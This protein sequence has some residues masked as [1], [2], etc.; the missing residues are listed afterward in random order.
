[1]PEIINS[2]VIKTKKGCRKNRQPFRGRERIRTAVQAFAE[3]CLATR[4]PDHWIA[5]VVFFANTQNHFLLLQYMTKKKLPQRKQKQT[6]KRHLKGANETSE[7]IFSIIKHLGS[8]ADLKS[9]FDIALD[10]FTQADIVSALDKLEQ[11]AKITVHQRGRIEVL[12]KKRPEKTAM[13][14]VLVGTIDITRTGAAYVKVQKLD[15]D[16]FIMER[17]TGGAL[18]GDTVEVQLRGGKTGRPEGI[19]TAIVK[20]SQESF[21]GTVHQNKTGFYFRP[22]ENRIRKIFHLDDA[23]CA[24]IRDG[25]R[26]IARILRW[27]Q[28][29]G[30]PDAEIVEVLSNQS[31]SDIEM[32]RILI[33][34]GFHIDF[35]SE[36]MQ[37]CAAISD[38]ISP[39]EIKKRTDYRDI[40][41]ITIDPADAKDFDDA[42]SYRILPNGDYEVGVHIADVAHYIKKGS[43]LDKEGE[44]RT[45][46]V[47]LPDRVC[48]MLP[49]RLSNELCSLRPNEDKLTFAAIFTFSPETLEMLTFSIAKTIIHSKRRFSYEEVQ[50]VLETKNGDYVNELLTLDKIA[51]NIRKLRT[52]KGAISFE[53]PEVRFKLDDTGKPIGIYTKVRKDAHLLIEDFMLLANESIAKFGSKLKVGATHQPFVYRVHDKPDA[54][55]LEQFSEIAKRFGY[56]VNFKSA[57]EVAGAMNIL[58]KKVEGKPEQN[59]LESLAIRSMAK[60]EYTTKNIGHYGLAMEFYTHFTSPIRRYPDVLVHRLVFE[61][62]NENHEFIAREELEEACRNSSLMERKAMDA[63][64]EATKYKQVEFLQDRIGETFDGIITGVIA[65]GIFVEL[66]ENKCEGFISVDNLGNDSFQFDEKTIS[67]KGYKTKLN[68]RLGDQLRVTVKNTNLAERKIDFELEL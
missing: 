47:Y 43:A 34:N 10:T 57:E 67:L 12:S 4:P 63:E 53:K 38:V 45:T 25:Q 49:E 14:K 6:S 56:N 7:T 27:K 30:K 66:T 15:R 16:V 11:Q 44:R 23:A 37:E 48:P 28:E 40:L 62:M 60:A 52:A 2:N 20:R 36:V 32:K 50:E 24:D 8:K 18:Q 61:S 33:Q 51:K 42:I 3:L 54:G 13:G 1:M 46:S 31:M 55:K 35:P 19:V 26:V 59:V 17:N 58:L 21:E 5:N 29:H 68:F 64:R 65:R 41:T 39:E 22:L 9:I